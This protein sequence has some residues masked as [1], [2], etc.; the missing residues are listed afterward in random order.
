[1]GTN[2]SSQRTDEQLDAILGDAGHWVINGRSGQTLGFAPS[3]RGALERAA[4]FRNSGA[5]V[6]ALAQLPNDSIIVFTPQ[7]DRLRK[8]IAGR[9]TA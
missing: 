6:I 2:H 4:G 7:I 3:L 5:V 9:E 8:I 1:M